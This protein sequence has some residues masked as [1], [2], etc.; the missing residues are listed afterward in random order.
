MDNISAVVVEFPWAR[1]TLPCVEDP[2][3]DEEEDKE[4]DNEDGP[5]AVDDDLDMFG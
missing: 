4:E 2:V 1:P 5:A 3:E